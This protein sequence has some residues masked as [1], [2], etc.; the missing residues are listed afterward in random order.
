MIKAGYDKTPAVASDHPTLASRVEAAD[1]WVKEL[2]PSAKEWLRPPIADESE[3]KRLQ[4]RANQVA[5]TTPDDTTLANSQQLLQA[6]PRSCII[7]YTTQ[8]EIQ[9]REAIVKKAEA[10]QQQGQQPPAGGTTKKK[11]KN[12]PPPETSSAAPPPGNQVISTP[13][14]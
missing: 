13:A 3:F 11:K 9:A 2:P 6:L 1:Q 10:A 5:K 7:P 12:P 4:A 14:R 8:D